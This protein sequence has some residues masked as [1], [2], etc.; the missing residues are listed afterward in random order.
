MLFKIPLNGGEEEEEYVK[1]EMF[2]PWK[3]NI[4]GDGGGGGKQATVI[5]YRHKFEK[6]VGIFRI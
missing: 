1:Y 5:Q 6:L 3:G 4:G 2:T